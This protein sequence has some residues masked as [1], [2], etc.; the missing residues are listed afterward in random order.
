[1]NDEAKELMLDLL[2]KKAVYGLET[3]QELSGRAP[4]A[5]GLMSDGS[6]DLAAAAFALVDL[7]TDVPM[8]AICIKD[9]DRRSGSCWHERSG[10]TV[11]ALSAASPFAVTGRRGSWYWLARLGCRG[12]GLCRSRD[13]SISRRHEIA[14]Q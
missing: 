6:L 9:P 10:R 3:Q 1:M 8:P 14:G 12:G 7:D 2:C 5:V 11:P 13:Q 4:R